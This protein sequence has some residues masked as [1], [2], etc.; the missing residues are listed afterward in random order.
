M[1]SD[2]MDSIFEEEL[3]P[4]DLSER[5]RKIL[6][7]LESEIRKLERGDMR[8][9]PTK[10]GNDKLKVLTEDYQGLVKEIREKLKNPSLKTKPIVDKLETSWKYIYSRMR[11]YDELVE[12]YN[13]AHDPK[14]EFISKRTGDKI[15]ESAKYFNY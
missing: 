10:D 4:V 8:C 7:L 9:P 15:E 3:N 1:A 12:I 6:D 2:F 11:R 14:L 5:A 13:K